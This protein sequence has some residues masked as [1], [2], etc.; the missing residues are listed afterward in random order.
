[1]DNIRI[2]NTGGTFNKIY[3]HISGNLEI[4]HNNEIITNLLN[5][6]FVHQNCINISGIIFK[7]SLE[8]SQEDRQHLADFVQKCEESKIIIIHGT[9]TMHISANFLNDFIPNK[10]VIFVGAM[11]PFSIEPIEATANLAMAI[12]AIRYLPNGIFVCMQGLLKS[13][14]KIEKNL[15]L[16]IFNVKN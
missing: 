11:R 13:F 5:K 14:D 1:M 15:E 16:G 7:D 6:A 8:F 9:D 4:N 12:G 3:N 2:V 10:T